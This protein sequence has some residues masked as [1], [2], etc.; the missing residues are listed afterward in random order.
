MNKRWFLFIPLIVVMAMSALFAYALLTGVDPKELPSALKGR[1]MPEFELSTV[2]DSSATL[3]AAD[4]KGEPYLLN[5]WATWCPSCK[6]E[7]PY[8]NAL[9]NEGVRIIGVDYKDDRDL[10]LQWLK[11]YANPYQIGLFDPNG[12]LGFELGVTG[13]PETFFVDSKGIIRHRFQGPID[14]AKWENE[15]KAIYDAMD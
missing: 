2:E 13:A 10:A 15:L 14:A 3:T 4:L 5:F 8:L 11:D 9:S 7:H 12:D 6:Y 1:E